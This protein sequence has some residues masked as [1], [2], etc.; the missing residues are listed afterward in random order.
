MTGVELA[1]QLYESGYMQLY[2]FSGK[3]F[4]KDEIPDY[5]KVITKGDLV[6]LSK[7]F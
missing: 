3:D 4:G 1:K 5:L 2:L 7:L 6:G